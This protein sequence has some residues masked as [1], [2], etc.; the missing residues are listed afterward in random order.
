MGLDTSYDAWNGSYVGFNIW[1]DTLAKVANYPFHD[2][3]CN[4]YI[5]SQPEIN[6]DDITEDNLAGKWTRI[7]E[8]PLIILIA[9]Y[10][11]DGKIMVEHLEPL[12]QR[13]EELLPLLGDEPDW[14]I[15]K[16]HTFING[17]REAS[18]EG[19]QIEFY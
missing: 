18:R 9:H 11:C 7:P 1:R 10:D 8:D 6:W 19:E 2:V 17:L 16:T 13:L 3:D 14:V 15:G 12:A 4:G 5:R